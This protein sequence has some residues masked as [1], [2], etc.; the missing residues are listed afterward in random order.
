[1]VRAFLAQGRKP[2]FLL[3]QP[4]LDYIE[5]GGAL[6]MAYQDLYQLLS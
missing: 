1:M 4:V 2:N 5:K 3:P 6:L